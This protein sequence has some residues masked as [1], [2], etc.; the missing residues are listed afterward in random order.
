M[1]QDE[2]NTPEKVSPII[3][4]ENFAVCVKEIFQRFEEINSGVADKRKKSPFLTYVENYLKLVKA[5]NASFEAHKPFY[6]E[7]FDKY[8]SSI[9]KTAD[10]DTW[11]CKNVVDVHLGHNNKKLARH[12]CIIKFSVCY[13][14]AKKIR[15]FME[16][17]LTGDVNTDEEIKSDYEFKYQDELLYRF[18]MIIRACL[19]D[20][21]RDVKKIDKTIQ[22]LAD[23][24]GI[25]DDSESSDEEK[26]AKN[27]QTASNL[28]S[29]IQ[30]MMGADDNGNVGGDKFM[31][32]LG[33][34]FNN[35]QITG[36]IGNAVKSLDTL[37]DPNKDPETMISDV[38]EAIKP[39][40]GTTLNA[41]RTD[42]PPP[43]VHVTPEGE[44][45][46]NKNIDNV[47]KD[48]SIEDD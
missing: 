7:I 36:Q 6:L 18:L 12:N 48:L 41:V 24:A 27:N 46:L 35:K 9:L 47:K 13:S 15:E 21:H 30:N 38:F 10:E 2:K 26:T 16:Q 5:A 33:N 1:D 43:G 44:E 25:N 17:K 19:D 22:I 20:N 34:V 23:R 14:K 4:V 11:L 40:V 39:V 45:I 8:R 29:G 42:Q 32:I 31:N 3:L 28:L 37:F